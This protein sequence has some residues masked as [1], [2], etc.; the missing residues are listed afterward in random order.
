MKNNNLENSKK[1]LTLIITVI[2][3]LIAVFIGVWL[4]SWKY[5]TEHRKNVYEFEKFTNSISS[6]KV[7]NINKLFELIERRPWFENYKKDELKE[8]M[9]DFIP[10]NII[11]L[12][13]WNLVSYKIIE[14]IDDYKMEDIISESSLKRKQIEWVLSKKIIIGSYDIFV[15]K[16]LKYDFWDYLFDVFIFL[17]SIV[18]LSLWFYYIWLKFVSKALKPVE[19]NLKDMQDFIHNAGHELK[20]PISVIHSNLQLIKETKKF[21]KDLVKELLFEINKLNHLIESLVELSNITSSENTEKIDLDEEIQVLIKD[22]KLDA[23]KKKIKINY[24][25]IQNNILIINKQ[26][27]YILLSNII[28]NAIK[29]TSKWWQIDITLDTESL[30]IKDNWYWISKQDLDKIFDRFYMWTSSRNSE[31]YGIWLSLV[32]KIAD[33]YNWKIEVKSKLEKGSEFKINF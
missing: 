7:T 16:K 5:I 31:G 23:Y 18:F 20:T 10:W 1:K 13:E 2:I 4:L 26:Y 27:F 6:T 12:N 8:R 22:L 21:E 30:K 25:K 15:F 14:K 24:K 19:E 28:Q 32:K 9:R 11:I 17:I 3:T 29:Y 33:I